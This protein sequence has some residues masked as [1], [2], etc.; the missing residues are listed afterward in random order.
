MK[1]MESLKLNYLLKTIISVCYKVKNMN[2]FWNFFASIRLLNELIDFFQLLKWSTDF[3]IDK[4][5]FYFLSIFCSVENHF[6]Q[7]K[8]SKVTFPND[9]SCESVL[10]ERTFY[11]QLFSYFPTSQTTNSNRFIALHCIRMQQK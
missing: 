2:D 9:P 7:E 5:T 1:I 3:Y 10:I 11:Q 4:Q 8:V 6:L